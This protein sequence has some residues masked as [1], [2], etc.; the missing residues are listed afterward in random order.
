MT[1]FDLLNST[2]LGTNPGDVLDATLPVSE[3]DTL[4]RE[5]ITWGAN[6][7]FVLGLQ[8]D[9]DRTFPE[10]V[11]LERTA[12]SSRPAN[13]KQPAAT[14]SRAEESFQPVN[15]R[16]IAMEKLHSALLTDDARNNFRLCGFGSTTGRLGHNSQHP[17]F[18]FEPLRDFSHARVTDF[19]LGQ[20]HT[21]ICTDKGDVWTFGLNSLSV[22]GYIVESTGTKNSSVEEPVQPVPKRIVGALKKEFVIGVAASRY[23]S[24]CFTSDALFTWGKNNGQLGYSTSTTPIQIAPRKVTAVTQPIKQIC[25]TEVATCCLLEGGEVFVLHRDTYYRI[26]FPVSRFPSAMQVYRPPNIAARPSVLKV[27]GSGST[28]IALTDLGDVFSWRLENPVTEAASATSFTTRDVKP[29]RI[30]EDRKSYTAAKDCCIADDTIVVCTRSGHVYVRS[31]RKELNSVRGFELKS[32]QGSSAPLSNSN[33][34]GQYKFT[35]ISN[36]QRVVNVAVSPSGGFAAIRSD[37]PLLRIPPAG[38]TLS[39]CLLDLLPHYRRLN[40]HLASDTRTPLLERDQQTGMVNEE[41]FDDDSIE[42][43][44]IA[45]DRMC[46]ILALWS[47]S[48]SNPDAGSDLL[49]VAGSSGAKLPVHAVIL[50]ARSVA[51]KQV[52]AGQSVKG[53]KLSRSGNATL[54]I[55]NCSHLS[56]L[57]LVHYLYSDEM[58]A[59]YDPRLFQRLQAG[60]PKLKIRIAELKAELQ[61]LAILLQLP[62][63]IEGLRAYGKTSVEPTLSPAIWTLRE[64]TF[65]ADVILETASED[66]V[67]HSTVLRARC[68]FFQVSTAVAWLENC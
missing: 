17:Q 63:L 34:K 61:S 14:E 53:L 5:L 26:T 28:F 30:W 50:S 33:K 22:L 8:G 56:A 66:I 43:D 37:A 7:N 4:R 25:A 10:R 27:A 2:I 35:R 49:L 57:L 18:A 6:R 54:H 3:E 39:K 15:V 41:D 29:T 47:P 55:Q 65:V 52:L 1:A 62:A 46:C 11:P 38:D 59:I 60:F 48:W 21:I 68:P 44:K 36:L 19:A 67:C 51:I 20:D 24:C 64:D 45:L 12:S 9:N 16:K 40:Q 32:S 42:S 58:P 13:G 23:H 31:R